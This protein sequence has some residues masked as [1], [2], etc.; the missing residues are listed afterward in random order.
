LAAIESRYG[1]DVWGR[2]GP[3]LERFVDAGLVIH[4]P[5]RRLALS[6]PGMLLANEVMTVFI[7]PAVR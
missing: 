7:S 6:R 3:E 1:I 2:Y 4:E 5:K